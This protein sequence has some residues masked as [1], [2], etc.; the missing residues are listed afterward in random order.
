MYR[1]SCFISVSGFTLLARAFVS[2]H[3]PDGASHE[4]IVILSIA[5]L[6]IAS[7]TLWY[8]FAN[9][10]AINELI[11]GRRRKDLLRLILGRKS[12]NS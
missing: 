4:V 12:E 9:R 6:A 7:L 1:L 8:F 11:Q 10:D 5:W 2:N 3:W